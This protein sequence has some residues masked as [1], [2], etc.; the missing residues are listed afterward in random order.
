MLKIR[1]DI[2]RYYFRNES[3]GGGTNI[4]VLTEFRAVR[5]RELRFI[6]D[7]SGIP[8]IH[9][10]AGGSHILTIKNLEISRYGRIL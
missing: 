5:D 9:V 2:E 7:R 3:I 10:T 8:K 4:I 6:R 1:R